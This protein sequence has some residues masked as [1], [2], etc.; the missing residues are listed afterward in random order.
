VV[1]AYSRVIGSDEIKDFAGMS[2]R[3]PGLALIM[4]VSFLSLSGMPPFGGFIAKFLVFSAAIQSWS[5]NGQAYLLILAILG[6]LNSIIGLYYY[7][8]VLKVAYLYRSDDDDKPAPV[9]AS[10][11]L[12]LGVLV[13]GIILIG[14]LFTPWLNWS[15]AAVAGMFY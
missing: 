2:R 6:V 1:T 8:T 7:L 3:A 9:P 11:Y 15:S 4:M 14:T 10:M 12:A 13:I 5:A